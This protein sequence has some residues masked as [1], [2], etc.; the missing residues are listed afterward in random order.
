MDSIG[1]NHRLE[2]A[3]ADLVDNSIDAA[4]THVLIRFVVARGKV[5]SLYV[6]DNG[7]GI[8]P[9]KIDDAMTAGVR[10]DYDPTE[11]GHFG[12][13]LKAASFS[14]A[15]SLT[16]IS[17]ANG[18]PPV[19]RRWLASKARE[20]FECDVVGE[21]FCAREFRRRWRF[22]DLTIGTII[23]WDDIQAFP[24]VRD[25]DATSRFITDATTRLEK[26]LGL[27]F[28][29]FLEDERIKIGIQTEFGQAGGVG[30][31]AEVKPLD[32]FGYPR[33]GAGGYPQS[34]HAQIDG[35]AVDVVCHVWPGRSQLPQFRLPGGSPERFQ[36]FYF[37]RRDRLLQAGGW[38]NVEVKRRDLQLGRAAIDLDDLL[39]ESN[40]FRMNPEKSRV[41]TGHEFSRALARARGESGGDLRSY[42]ADAQSAFKQ[43][44]QR[45]RARAQVAPLGRGV[46][47][48][49]R[50]AVRHELTALPGQEDVDIRWRRLRGDAFFDIDRESGTIWLNAKYRSAVL[51]DRP[52]TFNDAP[53]LKTLVY[54]LAEN[55]FHGSW[56]GPKDRDNIDLWQA[57][58]T[59][60]AKEE[61][62]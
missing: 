14:Q 61:A 48:R 5:Q 43:A 24:N 35:R 8:A 21:E 53:L 20:S 26:H 12:L 55:L 17:R 38:N 47:P 19:G 45:R 52:S 27:V 7:L 57:L 2:T 40:V 50:R 9:D 18:S 51:G 4:A 34:L 32:P 37:Y 62:S 30:L 22:F 1:R 49:L 25:E 54:L 10:R 3:A 23:R 36:G 44:N 33:S 6:V 59:A 29:R 58:L 11:L 46:P 39:I 56:L 31:T 41:E 28:H 16:V 42:F 15:G 13:G 60:A